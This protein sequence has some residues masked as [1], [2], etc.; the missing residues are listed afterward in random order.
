M[1]QP[2]GKQPAKLPPITSL[3]IGG[4]SLSWESLSRASALVP[5][6]Q[7]STTTSPTTQALERAA[8]AI[9]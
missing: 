6:H 5:F 4:F 3:V 9:P 7:H 2:P 1:R 8:D